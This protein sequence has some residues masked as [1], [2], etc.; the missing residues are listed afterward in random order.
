MADSFFRRVA[1]FILTDGS[2]PTLRVGKW[3]GDLATTSMVRFGCGNYDNY[4][5]CDMLPNN[6][7]GCGF[8]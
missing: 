3:C 4:D 5:N 2:D 7:Q 1:W 6:V 8:H